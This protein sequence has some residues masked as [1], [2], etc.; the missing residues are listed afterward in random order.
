MPL[1]PSRATGPPSSETIASSLVASVPYQI[2][3]TTLRPSGRA[4]GQRWSSSPLAESGRVN[5]ASSPP[6]TLTLASPCTLSVAPTTSS[7]VVVQSAPLAAAAR[8]RWSPARC[9][10]AGP[11]SPSR[12]PRT[13]ATVRRA[14]T[15]PE[16][17]PGCPGSGGPRA[18]RSG[19]GTATCFRP[20]G[21]EY[22]RCHRRARSRRPG[23]VVAHLG[24]VGAGEAG[25]GR[26]RQPARAARASSFAAPKPSAAA[27]TAAMPSATRAPAARRGPR[28]CAASRRSAPRR[29]GRASMRRPDE[30]APRRTRRRWRTGRPAASRAP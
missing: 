13:R 20:G 10:R 4:I 6:A 11:S 9:R 22:T 15:A 2:V 3:N 7:S 18:G 5:W 14:R 25:I 24:A 21:T 27:A 19:A 23:E 12:P 30:P 26:R 8:R 16:R 17:R 1:S 29:S 28:G